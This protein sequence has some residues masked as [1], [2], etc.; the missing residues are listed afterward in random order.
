MNAAMTGYEIQIFADGRWQTTELHADKADS[1]TRAAA[2][3]EEG[4]GEKVRVVESAPDKSGKSIDRTIFE[5]DAK[6][7]NGGAVTAQPVDTVPMCQ[8]PSDVYRLESR[9][10]I[11]RILRSYLDDENLT[12]A[13]LIT[14]AGRL[15][16]L[17]RHEAMLPQAIGI[18]AGVQAR[19]TGISQKERTDA[20][21]RLSDGVRETAAALAEHAGTLLQVLQT[22]GL[23]GLETALHE[24]GETQRLPLRVAAMAAYLREAGDPESRLGLLFELVPDMDDLSEFAHL[25]VDEAIA[26]TLDGGEGVKSTIGAMPDLASATRQVCA[27]SRGRMELGRSASPIQHKVNEI[28]RTHPMPHTKAALNRWVSLSMSSL[29][30]LTREGGDEERRAFA[31][32]LTAMLQDDGLA[33]GAKTSEAV[34]QRARSILVTDPYNQR[35][36]DAIDALLNV[37]PAKSTRV[38]YLADVS[39][40]ETVGTRA[41]PT[42]VE[43]LVETMGTV[44]SLGDLAPSGATRKEAEAIQ[45]KLIRKVERSPLPEELRQHIATKISALPPGGG[46]PTAGFQY[47]Q[48]P[49]DRTRTFKQ[50]DV[51]FQEGDAGD[52]AY[53]VRKGAVQISISV[54]GEDT[55]IAT[56]GPGEIFGEMSLIDDMPRAAN[57]TARAET[58]VVVVRAGPFKKRLETLSE[59]DPVLRHLI[60]VYV[61]RL[62]LTVKRLL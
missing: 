49:G 26:E 29:Q 12:A 42:I 54:D 45:E 8:A 24:F 28:L 40:T 25:A 34:T 4:A 46:R 58:E 31:D 53:M 5:Q 59:N 19:A 52:A 35:I 23:A 7:K 11:G 6:K 17:A 37:I 55:T 36:E 60:D 13:D 62:R 27:L 61:R 56:L 14:D 10:T 1:L 18:A 3:A 38:G 20:L 48:K 16:Q 15:S 2:L 22:K 9:L 21:Y 57:A 51:I 39:T 30:P 47:I 32:V 33:G 41:A 43:Y 50:G 44:R